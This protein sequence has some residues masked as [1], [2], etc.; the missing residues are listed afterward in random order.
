MSE[1]NIASTTGLD[2]GG[3]VHRISTEAGQDDLDDDRATIEASHL[4]DTQ[5]DTRIRWVYLMLGAATLLSWNAMINA[6]SFFMSRLA[7]SPLR[8]SFSSYLSSV[9]T[10]SNV[11]TLGHAIV[12]S[13]QSSPSR[14]AFWAT[15]L[16]SAI[17]TILFLTTF[18]HPSPAP[19]FYF[20]MISAFC[21]SGCASYLSNSVFAGAA[22]FGAPYMQSVMSGQAAVA[23]AVSSV[24]VVSSA[25]S[26][27]GTTPLTLGISDIDPDGKAEE[28]SARIFFGISALYMIATLLAYKWLASLQV[29]T[30]TMGA[31]EDNLKTR[32]VSNEADE[33]QPLLPA[34][35]PNAV[36]G[37]QIF[38]IFQTNFIYNFAVGFV[39][40][41]TL[42]VYPAITVTIK[43]TNTNTHPLLF[44]AVHFLVFSS[45]DL[46]GRH[47][48]SFP[49]LII[50]SA[51]RV[52]ALSLLRTL[53][54]PM[55]LLCNVEHS[56]PVAPF[57]SSD[58]LYMLLMCALGVSNGYVSTLCMLGAPSLEHNKRLRGRQ[59]DIDV[60]STVAAFCLIVGLAVGGFAS[61]GV[62]AVICD[63]NPFAS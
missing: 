4:Q 57:I 56:L 19:F 42:A 40:T 60:A 41:V 62:R 44:S 9:F 7:G 39:F 52:L 51:R 33:R 1:M 3:G 6:N 48:C 35:L 32:V 17:V 24:Q 49:K 47:M 63:C 45:G 25:I 2:V 54:I 50:W 61:F 13:K 37:N 14:R 10:A 43:P 29:Y 59:E 16:T 46:L 8:I 53:F 31:L 18:I 20:I 11:V 58:L 30:T 21:L 55:F 28:K 5:G 15:A 22:L 23:V 27:W 26:V 34:A 38:R 36:E 12:T